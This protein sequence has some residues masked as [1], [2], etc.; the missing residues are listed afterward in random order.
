V[1]VPSPKEPAKAKQIALTFGNG[2]GPMLAQTSIDFPANFD[3]ALTPLDKKRPAGGVTVD[4]VAI[5][6]VN[7]AGGGGLRYDCTF[8]L[9]N[10]SAKKVSVTS[11]TVTPPKGDA[12][13]V[14]L[15]VELPGRTETA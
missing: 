2:K 5:S 7:V 14:A 9:T 15:P 12:V 3:V 4:D 13:K 11:F 1:A 6:R 8:S 10:A